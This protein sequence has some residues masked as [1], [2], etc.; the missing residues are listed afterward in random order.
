MSFSTGY[1]TV[2]ARKE[3]DCCCFDIYLASGYGAIDVPCEYREA[4]HDMRDKKGKIQIGEEY[5]MWS[6]MADGEFFTARA[7]KRMHELICEMEWFDE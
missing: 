3:H 5:I 1:K 4:I 2:T 6:G 7:N